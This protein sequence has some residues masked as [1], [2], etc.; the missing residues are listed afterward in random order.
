SWVAEDDAARH[1]HLHPGRAARLVGVGGRAFGSIGE[2]HPRI[3]AAWDLPGRPVMAV[4]NLGQLAEQLPPKI[5]AAS[6][7]AAAQPLDRD[8]AVMVDEATPVGELLRI[9]R[10]SAGPL[11]VEAHLFDAYRG[12]QIGAGKVSYAIALRFQPETA[13]DE[14]GVDR[15]MGRLRGALEHHLAAQLR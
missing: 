15:A 13:G 10:S 9:V 3:A 7:P 4:I 2:I 14:R 8:L 5:G 1:P 12:P 11:L 6:V